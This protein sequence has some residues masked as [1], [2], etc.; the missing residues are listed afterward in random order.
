MRKL[1]RILLFGVLVYCSGLEL[2]A[3]NIAITDDDTYSANPS[4]MLDIKSLTKGMLVPRLSTVQRNAVSNPATGLLVFDT[5]KASFYF[6]NGTSWLNLTSGNA[7]GILG[8]TS[9]DKVYLSDVN[10]K[11]GVG[12]VSPSGKM[13]VK[14]D[15]SIGNELPIFNVVNSTGDTVFAVYEQGV[16]INVY[17][18]P[19]LKS[20][21]S[22][23]GFA[24]GGFS[25]AKGTTTNEYL[26]VTPDSVRVY[27]EEGNVNKATGSKGGFAV[28]G[29]SPAKIGTQTDYFN[30]YGSNSALTVPAM[31]P[32]IFWY[33]KKEA[34]LAGKVIV[35]SPDSVGLN[36]FSTGYISRAKGDYSQAFGYQSIARGNYS[37][38][39]GKNAIAIRQ[40]S[41]AIGD[42][43]KVTADD[44][45]AI[46]AGAIAK[47]AGSYAIGSMSRDS[48]GTAG[49]DVTLAQ[50]D[51][52]FAI[53]QGAM[54][55]GLGSMTYGVNSTATGDFS[56]AAGQNSYANS[57]G[58]VA[59]GS[60]NYF[61]VANS[62]NF[63]V[64]TD[65]IFVVGNGF[66]DN[67]SNALTLLKNGN[68]GLNVN[69][70][71]LDFEL[72]ANNNR[73]IGLGN[74]STSILLPGGKS[75]TILAGSPS[76]LS[77]NQN[78]GALKLKAGN[79]TGSGSSSILFFTAS[80]G[81]V[82]A[83]EQVSTEKMRIDGN[84]FVGIGNSNPN[85]T[86][87]VNGS[88]SMPIR[89]V[90]SNTT[91]DE[92]DY[93]VLV[94][95]NVTISLPSAV[96]CNGRVYVIKKTTA[97]PG[98]VTIDPNGAQTIDGSLTRAISTSNETVVI[99]SNG[100]VWY[101]IN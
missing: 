10:D 84:G 86:L 42:G 54:S 4:A 100:T 77:S 20:T 43:A 81:I 39:I 97:L 49:L 30:I 56:F 99:Q 98:S 37:T 60:N 14:S 91:L 45:Y 11:F 28:G 9:P 16:R 34:F 15:M 70:P 7:N 96:D 55:V 35:E 94:N 57:Y 21:G 27:I 82:G 64:N 95:A 71:T 76:L 23:G 12:T 19:V 78:G 66:K 36:S 72:N 62:A 52:S 83:A 63:W 80:P 3:Q 75:L 8:Y 88:V 51:F 85:S 22:K 59:L 68:L 2:S 89:M 40:N 24:V 65:P 44:A 25:P 90:A 53:G 50:G 61:S 92:N 26:R 58:M 79:S 48:V 17:D 33:P 87:T 69:E 67:R 47:G 38:A 18:D 13:E 93:T 6:Y 5:D 46:G 29:F 32:R 74:T 101:K 31:V 73:V 1:F 41:F